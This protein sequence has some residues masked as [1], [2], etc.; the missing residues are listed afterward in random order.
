MD[1]KIIET[2][3]EKAK[4]WA[5][6]EY[7]GDN[8]ILLDQ[9]ANAPFPKEPRRMNFILLGLCTKG[10]V[11]YRMD[12]QEQL[13]TPGHIIVASERHIIDQCEA[14]PDLEGLCMMMSTP[15]YNEIMSNVSD[16]SALFLFAHN[17]PIFPF[18]ERDQQVFT[19]YFHVIRSKMTESGSYFRHDLVRTLMLAMFYDLAGVIYQFQQVKDTRQT[20]ADV[21]FTQFI[22]L[23]EANCRQER[24]VSWYAK[25]LCI[26]PKYLSET[27]KHVSQ[28]TPNE[29]IDNYVI[30]E[31]RVLLKNTSQSIKEIAKELHFPNQSFLGKYFKEHVGMSPSEYRKS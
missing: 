8:L 15:F 19:D 13:L 6:C 30:L 11:R 14:S 4:K 1:K 25:Q 18:S 10:S 7:L 27:V 21:I 2:N 16:L 12:M 24:R 29:W 26:T 17:H 3:F 31:A 22:H 9:L 23:V 5:G 28:R 20:R